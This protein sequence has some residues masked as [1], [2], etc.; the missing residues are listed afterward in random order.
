[1]PL[2]HFGFIVFELL[3][4]SFAQSFSFEATL[5]H[6][7]EPGQLHQPIDELVQTAD[8]GNVSLRKAG[9]CRIKAARIL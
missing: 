3:L 4:L 7:A 9:D 6:F 2:G 8:G 5:V 1:M